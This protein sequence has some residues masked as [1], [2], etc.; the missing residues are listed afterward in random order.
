MVENECKKL[1]VVNM[2]IEFLSPKV[3]FVVVV[4]VGE[5]VKEV[6]VRK[7]RRLEVGRLKRVEDLNTNMARKNKITAGS[8]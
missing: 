1:L 5:T 4:F 6:A 8:M 2:S 7:K 3:V